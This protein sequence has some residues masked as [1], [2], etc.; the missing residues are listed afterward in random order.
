MPFLLALVLV[1]APA[2][3]PPAHAPLLRLQG[4]DRLYFTRVGGAQRLTAPP[5]VAA[6]LPR[7]LDSR[8]SVPLSDESG[9]EELTLSDFPLPL[10]TWPRR[11]LL[12]Q[13]VDSGHPRITELWVALYD[14][15]QRSDVW[16]FQA[17]PQLNDNKLLPNYWI[18][19][20][21]AGP[22]RT[23]IVRFRGMMA[24]PQG[25]WWAAGRVVTLTAGNGLLAFAHMRNAFVFTQGYDRGDESGLP[26][27]AVSVE[28]EVGGRFE[29]R[30]LGQVPPEV[31]KACGV[32]SADEIAETW[33]EMERVA[34]CVTRAPGSTTSSRTPQEPSFAE[35]GSE[36]PAPL[37]QD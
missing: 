2:A 15:G 29:R 33:D 9:V 26:P 25:A 19:D 3:S 22:D 4:L 32:P 28:H 18:E 7:G 1:A 6:L 5:S 35:R 20:T 13:V 10:P 36:P 12:R 17:A 16:H 34:E 31:L 23:V 11:V 8:P 27:L 30:D 37:K 14:G 21:E 24:R